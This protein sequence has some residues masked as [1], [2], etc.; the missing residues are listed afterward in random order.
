M[1]VFLYADP[2]K[3]PEPPLPLLKAIFL[4]YRLAIIVKGEE[5]R[6][7]EI[8][9]I[10]LDMALL[11]NEPGKTKGQQVRVFG[12]EITGRQVVGRAVEIEITEI[13]TEG[14]GPQGKCRCLNSSGV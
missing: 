3:V 13:M 9:L 6:P 4:H 5:H 2:N 7:I 1:S 14:Q 10:Q 12:T 11:L 8:L